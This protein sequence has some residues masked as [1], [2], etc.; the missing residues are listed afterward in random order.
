MQS[1]RSGEFNQLTDSSG[2]QKMHAFAFNYAN[3][4]VKFAI[5]FSNICN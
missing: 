2:Y 1:E 3:K 5:T 4:F